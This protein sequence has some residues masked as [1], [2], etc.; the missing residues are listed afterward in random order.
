V[1]TP[2]PTPDDIDA[3]VAF[4]PLLYAP[5]FQPVKQWHGGT[6]NERGVIQIPFPEYEKVVTDF[7]ALACSDCWDKPD[8]DPRKADHLVR[9]PAAIKTASLDQLKT[10]L[11]SCVRGER[12][13][14]G[15]WGS[16]IE[17][18]TIRMVLERL[19]KL[20]GRTE[21]FSEDKSSDAATSFSGEQR[22]ALR[23]LSV[24]EEAFELDAASAIWRAVGESQKKL[25][26][27]LDNLRELGAVEVVAALSGV[28]PVFRLSKTTRVTGRRGLSR[29][30]E[31]KVVQQAHAEYFVSLIE[32]HAESLASPG[33]SEEANRFERAYADLGPALIWL[34][35]HGEAER[36]L[37]AAWALIPYWRVHSFAAG[38]RLYESLLI[39]TSLQEPT[40][41]QLFAL[42]I[43]ARLAYGAGDFAGARSWY[44]K[45]LAASRAVGLGSHIAHFLLELG[46]VCCLVGDFSGSQTYCQELFSQYDQ[47]LEP[48]EKV[49]GLELLATAALDS[50]DS[51]TSREL[52][53]TALVI[54]ST[55][56]E[57]N[58]A[59]TA[60]L[61]NTLG[62]VAFDEGNLDEAY[63][64][65]TE[66]LKG[67]RQL[68]N[69]Q[70]I[71]Y[72]LGS[73]GDTA[74]LMKRYADARD[75]YKE[76]MEVQS[77]RHDKG[78][79]CVL[80]RDL[81]CLSGLQGQYERALILEGAARSIHKPLNDYVVQAPIQKLLDEV[82]STAHEALGLPL[83]HA[84][85]VE[86]QTM[87]LEDAVNYAVSG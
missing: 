42:H 1:K 40:T 68:G 20:R 66:S 76:G 58:S 11:T 43:V 46:R 44:E 2:K 78:S 8:Y 62:H 79:I 45:G 80:L 61:L 38:R 16:V 36:A 51:D 73:V 41:S 27:V 37:N 69:R 50:H 71:G 35:D 75:A 15:H 85:L 77:R 13:S 49:V 81:A 25:L 48:D 7:F 9:H 6:A 55:L 23:R 14:D 26:A 34:I 64:L 86:G 87:S 39:A 67:W 12:F 72:L 56:K 24:F 33:P 57:T 65:Y 74:L 29:S 18:G 82:I 5:G 59:S 84:K 83:A 17:S 32:S 53:E 22:V 47:F 10:V 4:L 30:K 21:S 70:G 28:P 3:L 19:R 63:R 60:G 31:S 54:K 52:L